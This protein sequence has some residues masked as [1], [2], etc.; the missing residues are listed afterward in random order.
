MTTQAFIV[1]Y[2]RTPI[3][4]HRGRL[5]SIRDDDLGATPLRAL[6]EKHSDVDCKVTDDVMLGYTCASPKIYVL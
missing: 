6:V 4:A 3:G 2:V 5:A 1:D